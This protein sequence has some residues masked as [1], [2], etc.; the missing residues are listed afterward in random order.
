MHHS[1]IAFYTV[2][3]RVRVC[4]YLARL[5]KARTARL[6]LTRFTCAAAPD[7]I[8]YKFVYRLASSRRFFASSR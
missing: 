5:A 7:F 6:T 8:R 2:C 3:A 4:V 1:R